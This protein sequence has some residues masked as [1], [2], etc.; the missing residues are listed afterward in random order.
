ML[1]QHHNEQKNNVVILKVG[2]LFSLACRCL[3]VFHFPFRAQLCSS[4]TYTM[5][6]LVSQPRW[7]KGTGKKLDIWGVGGG[8]QAN[9]LYTLLSGLWPLVDIG[10]WLDFTFD[11]HTWEEHWVR[12]LPWNLYKAT[13]VSCL[14]W[15]WEPG[16]L[17]GRMSWES[18]V[19]NEVLQ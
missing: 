6:V 11:P 2:L 13:E 9:S 12:A 14:W 8:C 15:H 1:S 17:L 10:L 18:V 7:S 16:R 4:V 5:Q 3:R 19:S